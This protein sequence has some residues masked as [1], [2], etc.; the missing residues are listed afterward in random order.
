MHGFKLAVFLGSFLKCYLAALAID[1]TFNKQ[2]GEVSH[3][4]IVSNL[5]EVY[6]F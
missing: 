4:S 2:K 1:S 5:D 3:I 6:I